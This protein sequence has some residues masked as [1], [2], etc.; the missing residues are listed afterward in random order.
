[1]TAQEQTLASIGVVYRRQR[2]ERKGNDMNPRPYDWADVRK[3]CKPDE[4]GTVLLKAS[5]A[6]LGISA[7]SVQMDS[8]S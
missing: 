5:M 2:G 7:R 3:H 6:Q 1:M 4:A 8:F